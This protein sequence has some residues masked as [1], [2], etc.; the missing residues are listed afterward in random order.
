VTV[1]RAVCFGAA[2]DELPNAGGWVLLV[3]QPLGML[4]ILLTAWGR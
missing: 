2:R 4:G 3:G 1:T